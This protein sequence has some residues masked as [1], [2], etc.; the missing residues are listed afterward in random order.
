MLVGQDDT[1]L[2]C[3]DLVLKSIPTIKREIIR[4]TMSNIS[5]K[6]PV[7]FLRTSSGFKGI[8]VQSE[9]MKGCTYFMYR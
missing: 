8:M 2:I 1:F 3:L 4:P 6:V 9:K 7:P 5:H